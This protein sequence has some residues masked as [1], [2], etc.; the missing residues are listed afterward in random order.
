MDAITKFFLDLWTIP[1]VRFIAAH[2][3]INVVVAVM[4]A[5]FVGEFKPHKLAE[6][7]SR[8]MLPYVTV[9][10]IVRAVGADAGLDAL[11]PVV[12]GIIE[13]TLL[14]DLLESLAKLGI[15]MPEPVKRLV[16]K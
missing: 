7:L 12:F 8:K 4:A 3:G 11:S 10:G 15:P 2:V 1:E 9:Y 5:L 16:S 13:A 14:A 6:F